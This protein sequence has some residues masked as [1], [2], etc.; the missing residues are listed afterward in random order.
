VKVRAA[1]TEERLFLRLSWRDATRDANVS[2]ESRYA[3]PARNDFADAAAVQL[4]VNTS[5]R[6][7]IAM[8]GPGERVNV[9]YWNPN[10]GS[11][12]L[13]AAGAGTT[14]PFAESSV[15]TAA[16]YRGGRWYVVFSRPLVADGANRTSIRLE[17]DVSVAFAVWNG[18][19]ME[20]SGRKAV[21]EWQY[22][23]FGPGPQGPP[24]EAVLWAIAGLAIV[25]VVLVTTLAV[26]GT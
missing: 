11:E 24:Y 9:W 14:T 22:F 8:G 10:R 7:G 15:E 25:V 18:S 21:S 13:L 16:T 12:E 19:N 23:P 3:A 20:R 5:A 26:R 6:P 17:R 2:A 1:R 4:P